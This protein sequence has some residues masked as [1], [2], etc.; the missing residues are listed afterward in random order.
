MEDTSIIELFWARSEDAILHAQLKYGTYCRSIAY[1]IL[2]SNED[3]EECESDTF[4]HAWNAMPP[5][6][7]SILSSFLGKITRN[8]SIDRLRKKNASKRGGEYA[9]IL[10]EVENWFASPEDSDSPEDGLDAELL[11]MYISH[12]LKTVSKKS[13]LLFIGRYW[14]MLS[15]VELAEKFGLSESAVKTSL[16]RTRRE[17][18]KYLTKEGYNI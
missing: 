8:L 16:H 17:L 1:S 2:H 3:A 11:A 7:P 14:N 18:A 12:F 10:D 5:H 9:A 13:R 4:L 6:H 15:V